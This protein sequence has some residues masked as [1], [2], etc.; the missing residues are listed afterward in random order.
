MGENPTIL[1]FSNPFYENAEFLRLKD[2][3]AKISFPPEVVCSLS[4]NFVQVP[5]YSWPNYVYIPILAIDHEKFPIRF[6]IITTDSPH[7]PG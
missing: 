3:S 5:T 4:G 2:L 1:F 6:R 7:A